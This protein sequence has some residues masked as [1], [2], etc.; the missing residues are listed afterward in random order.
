MLQSVARLSD[1]LEML[2]AKLIDHAK[3]VN[4]KLDLLSGV[5]TY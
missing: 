5:H 3:I 2:Q 4:M 1:A